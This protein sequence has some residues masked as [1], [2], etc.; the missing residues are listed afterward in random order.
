MRLALAVRTPIFLEG[1]SQ[2]YLLPGWE[3]VH[4]HGFSPELRRAPIYPLF[5]GVGL[6]VLGNDL[7]RLALV[8]QLLGLVSAL[9]AYALG[10]RLF[11]TA[12]G[13]LAGLFVALSGPLLIYERY[14]MTETLFGFVLTLAACLAVAAL[15]R[16]SVF[17][18][19]PLGVT[20]GAAALIRPV[21]QAL[22][23]LLLLAFLLCLPRWRVALTAS[24]VALLGYLAI[25]AP[26]T[27]R[28]WVAHEAPTTAGGLGRSLIARSVKY[29]SLV[30]WKWLSET[31]GGREDAASRARMLLYRKR[32]N[33]PASR[34]VRPYQDALIEELGVSQGQAESLMRGVAFEVIQQNPSDYVVGSLQFT[35]LILLGREERIQSH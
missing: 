24:G 11:G 34:S 31:Y 16:P 30:D 3:L 23:P 1:D 27:I 13:V 22:I 5:V 26:W 4:G 7:Q 35:E 33:I 32:G 14:L 28:N 6:Q 9:L 20:L 15:D 10:K 2:S 25:V 17:R 19:L 8:Q 18:V 21:G 29:D 12:A